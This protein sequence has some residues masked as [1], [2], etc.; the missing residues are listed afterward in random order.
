MIPRR[1]SDIPPDNLKGVDVLSTQA[2]GEDREY[3]SV[4][5]NTSEHASF[6]YCRLGVLCS[7]TYKSLRSSSLDNEKSTLCFGVKHNMCYVY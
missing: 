2:D 1:L 6:V 4:R 3:I 7:V 5:S